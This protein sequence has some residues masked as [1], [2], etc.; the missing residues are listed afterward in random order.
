MGDISG[1]SV[2]HDIQD[3]HPMNGNE[4]LE[5]HGSLQRRHVLIAENIDVPAKKARVTGQVSNLVNTNHMLH[6]LSLS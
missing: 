4:K 5:L 2:F 6:T 3:L 1:L